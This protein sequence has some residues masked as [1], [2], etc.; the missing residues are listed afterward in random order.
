ME[1]ADHDTE[2]LRGHRVDTLL[3]RHSWEYAKLV[4]ACRKEI[5]TP[6]SDAVVHD[7]DPH[8]EMFDSGAMER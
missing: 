4:G 7:L 8:A 1:D 3:T 6:A 2:L 5:E